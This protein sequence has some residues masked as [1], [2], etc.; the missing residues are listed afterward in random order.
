MWIIYCVSLFMYWMDY[1]NV[2][3]ISH[4]KLFVEIHEFSF[5]LILSL[6]VLITISMIYLF[7]TR[8]F[9]EMWY[10]VVDVDDHNLRMI[11][12]NQSLGPNRLNNRLMHLSVKAAVLSIVSLL[13]SLLWVAPAAL[14][15]FI[16]LSADSVF[17]QILTLCQQID[18]VIC[19]LCLTL[20]LTKARRLYSV[21]CSCCIFVG[22]QPMRRRLMQHQPVQ[23]V[24]EYPDNIPNSNH[25][26]N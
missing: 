6:D 18:T 15:P 17:W 16:H 7:V 14:G 25:A 26:T 24:P 3:N 10:Q 13:S 12:L 21:L 9:M 8:L 19:S 23:R 22:Y 1:L 2:F 5:I 20:F 11:A 4:Q